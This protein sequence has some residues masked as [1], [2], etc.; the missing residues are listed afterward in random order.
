MRTATSSSSR[1]S[2]YSS[3]T[4]RTTRSVTSDHRS[5]VL[6]SSRCSEWLSSYDEVW[7]DGTGADYVDGAQPQSID[8]FYLADDSP[9]APADALAVEAEAVR[10]A[11]TEE[12]AAV[13][14]ATF[15]AEWFGSK[16][17]R[18]VED[19]RISEEEEGQEEEA[20]TNQL[21]DALVT[22]HIPAASSLRFPLLCCPL[23]AHP[24]DA[25][26]CECGW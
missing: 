8:Y 12:A 22:V 7:E 25:V 11:V 4:P 3:S 19:E 5:A 18:V 23:C 15:P 13:D 26:L 14:T 10:E 24:L 2:S 1:Y 9:M 17:R 16:R 20:D 21:Q 6:P